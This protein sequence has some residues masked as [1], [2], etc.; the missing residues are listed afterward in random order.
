MNNIL[1]IAMVS[2]FCL[3]C[4]SGPAMAALIKDGSSVRSATQQVVD[5][6]QFL[7]NRKQSKRQ[8]IKGLIALHGKGIDPISQ[9]VA[10]KKVSKQVKKLGNSYSSLAKKYQNEAASYTQKYQDAAKDYRDEAG[11]IREEGKEALTETRDQIKNEFNRYNKKNMK[12]VADDMEDDI[13]KKAKEIATGK[14]AIR[15]ID[16]D[17]LD[18]VDEEG[19]KKSPVG[20]GVPTVDVANI[21]AGLYNLDSSFGI[22]D[23]NKRIRDKDTQIC[24]MMGG[25]GSEDACCELWAKHEA[26]ENQN[27]KF[28]RSLGKKSRCCKLFKQGCEETEADQK[29]GCMANQ[30]NKSVADACRACEVENDSPHYIALANRNIDDLSETDKEKLVKDSMKKEVTW[31]PA[32]SV[33]TASEMAPVVPTEIEA[34]L[35]ANTKK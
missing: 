2:A 9:H 32:A 8:A 25:R 11:E 1:K 15:W 30:S 31:S 5:K 6:T 19:D 34:K 7:G 17:V 33:L 22:Y 24:A 21:I 3:M 23:E 14:E 29:L 35:K 4:V 10:M 20:A 16:Q 26:G 13:R 27:F 12:E 18:A 28:E